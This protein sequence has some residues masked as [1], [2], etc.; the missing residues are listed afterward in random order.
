MLKECVLSLP[1]ESYS[2]RARRVSFKKTRGKETT[3]SFKTLVVVVVVVVVVVW[4]NFGASSTTPERTGGSKPDV[5]C[6]RLVYS[7]LLPPPFQLP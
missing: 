3:R 7:P 6:V 4:P 1:P 5:L 2:T